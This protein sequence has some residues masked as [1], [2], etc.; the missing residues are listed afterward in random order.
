MIKQSLPADDDTKA[1]SRRYCSRDGKA[2]VP[3][4]GGDVVELYQLRRNHCVNDTYEHFL[5]FYKKL[6]R[7]AVDLFFVGARIDTIRAA[8]ETSTFI[9]NL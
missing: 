7:E 4:P 1:T 8:S 6:S 5:T 2:L 3:R 9:K